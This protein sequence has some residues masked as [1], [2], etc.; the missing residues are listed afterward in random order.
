MADSEEQSKQLE[1]AA[2][3]LTA[4]TKLVE[5]QKA[6]FAQQLASLAQKKQ[7]LSV[8][9]KLEVTK[10]KLDAEV[11]SKNKPRISSKLLLINR[12]KYFERQAEMQANVKSTQAKIVELQQAAKVSASM[13]S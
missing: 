7:Q 1:Q 9:Q 5:K 4:M 10:K 6:D 11:V 8:S 12:N 13:M 2:T 3:E